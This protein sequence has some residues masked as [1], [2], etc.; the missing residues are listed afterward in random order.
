MYDKYRKP[1]V[2]DLNEI[3]YY[4]GS[5][6]DQHHFWTGLINN[7]IPVI[8]PGISDGAVGNQIWLFHQQHNDFKD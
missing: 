1:D 2:S 7:K 6:L 3:T 4:I 8:V 5:N